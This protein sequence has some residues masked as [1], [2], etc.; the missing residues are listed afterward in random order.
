ML[1]INR[2]IAAAALACALA[3]FAA[4]V[5]VYAD[6]MVVTSGTT[7]HIN[8]RS[9]PGEDYDTLA[10]LSVGTEV[11]VLGEEGNWYKI[12]FD[13]MTG[14]VRHDLLKEGASSSDTSSEG[15][16]TS[17]TAADTTGS[18]DAGTTDTGADTSDSGTGSAETGADTSVTSE[19]AESTPTGIMVSGTEYTL[20]SSLSNIK[21]DSLPSDVTESEITYA[22]G[23]YPAFYVGSADVY[24]VYMEDAEGNGGFFVFDATAMSFV[25]YTHMEQGD[26]TI[27][28]MNAPMGFAA[29]AA[30]DAVSLPA[31]D[32]GTIKAYRKADASASSD[33][34]LDETSLYTVYAK[35][36]DGYVGWITYDDELKS[37]TRA[38]EPADEAVAEADPDEDIEIAVASSDASK[39]DDSKTIKELRST[40]NKVIAVLIVIIVILIIVTVNVVVFRGR[41]R[42]GEDDFFDDEYDAFDDDDMAKEAEEIRRN[43]NMRRAAESRAQDQPLPV[44]DPSKT[45]KAS[46]PEATSGEDEK[47]KDD[48]IHMI[49]LN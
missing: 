12:S 6:T 39:S 44:R 48:D 31:D 15:S 2:K 43:L 13:G 8:V 18:T 37:V 41:R 26:A 45:I 34:G 19:G 22:G 3:L 25:P 35:S 23:T 32:T 38:S 49:D 36:T 33:A 4:G 46:S 16:G 20:A 24:I 40:Y 9:G 21:R 27:I 28:F 47:R 11:E 42:R 29:G 1:G 7:S 14:Y 5:P 30:Y 17:D 10:S